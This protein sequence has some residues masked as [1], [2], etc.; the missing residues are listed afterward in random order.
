MKQITAEQVRALPEGTHVFVGKVDER[1]RLE[2]ELAGTGRRMRLLR[3][4]QKSS[5]L[6]IKDRKGWG[7]Y[8]E[9]KGEE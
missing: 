9:E 4:P 3:L 5:Y 1:M 2:Y 8:V 6:P 7:Y